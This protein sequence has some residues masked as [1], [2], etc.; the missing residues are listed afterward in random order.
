MGVLGRN[1]P[2]YCGSGKKYK[3]CCLKIDEEKIQRGI[4]PEPLRKPI[5]RTSHDISFG[6]KELVLAQLEQIIMDLSEKH[7]IPDYIIFNS[8][9][10]LKLATTNDMVEHYLTVT[11]EVMELKGWQYIPL[12]LKNLRERARTLPSLTENER[13]ILK[14]VVQ[15]NLAEFVMLNDF[16]T[17][18][19]SAM[20]INNEFCYQA[21]KNGVP[22]DKHIWAITLYVDS[23]GNGK[24]KLV[25]W[26]FHYS[27]EPVHDIWFD[28][29]P[30]DQL[31]D[32]YRKYAHSMHGL[33]EES[34]NDLAT[35]MYQE[36]AIPTKSKDKV[37]YRG[38]V[39][40]YTGIL[41]RELKLLIEM[42]EGK[43]MP[44]LTMKK[45]NEYL[46]GNE[47]PYLSENTTALYEKLEEVRKIRNKAAHGSADV[48]YNDFLKVKTLLVDKQLLEYISWA[49]VHYEDIV[50]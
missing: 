18:D 17:A 2:C 45:I 28:W 13:L 37:S 9:D 32:E 39:T 21:I 24:E 42:N 49:K 29:K 1:E 35:V 30:L 48:S 36:K 20:K 34:K 6:I 12:E 44:D 27:E 50:E 25:N 5:K 10:L 23:D 33:E 4:V 22:D 15:S 41:E 46:K 40:T 16:Q 19:Y 31:N 3:K 8:Q 38:M 47:I 11:R 43:K 7:I 14:T 26:E